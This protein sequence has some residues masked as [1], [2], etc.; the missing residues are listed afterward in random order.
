M[1]V[2]DLK[3]K[4]EKI[5]YQTYE[6]NLSEDE[7]EKLWDKKECL[8]TE[9]HS[10]SSIKSINGWLI[11]LVKELRK[12]QPSS[13][14]HE[15]LIDKILIMNENNARKQGLERANKRANKD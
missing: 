6:V 1:T 7:I 11:E 4:I 8:K 13:K 14:I 3:K 2:G 5:L 9:R 12:P 15:E 10:E